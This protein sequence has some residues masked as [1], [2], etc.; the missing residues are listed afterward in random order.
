[1]SILRHPRGALRVN[2]DDIEGWLSIETEENEFSTADTFRI[3]LSM[4]GLPLDR[5]PKWWMETQK[6]EVEI[7]MG[8]PA[9]PDAFG[10]GDLT[11]VFFGEVDAVEADWVARVINISGRD[12]TARLL[13]DKTSEKFVNLTASEIVEKFA[14]KHGLTPEVTKTTTKAGRYYQIDHV[15]LQD[16]RTAWDIVSWLAHEEGFAAYVR[17]RT[18]YFGPRSTADDQPAFIITRREADQNEP[19][20]GNYTRLATYRDLG[21]AGDIHVTVKSW[22]AKQKKGFTRTA[23][24]GG[25]EAKRYSYTIPGL[26]PDQAKDKARAILDDLSRHALRL[27]YEGAGRVDLHVS[28]TILLQGTGT[29][30]DQVYFPEA[31]RRTLNKGEGLSWSISAKN[32]ATD[33]EPTL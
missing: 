24:S 16:E 26:S 20:R 14:A 33:D 19:E 5:G 11:S 10:A 15:D 2:G 13:D 25:G 32:R 1:M 22:N 27:E 9:N 12:L 23:G 28:Q 31:I 30:W 18:L 6:A 7:F 29:G 3:T 21:V 8:L 17:G 4:S